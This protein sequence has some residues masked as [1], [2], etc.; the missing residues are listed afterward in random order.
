MKPTDE[1]FDKD[2]IKST[3]FGKFYEDI[4]R[5]WFKNQKCFEVLRGKPKVNWLDRTPSEK[6]QRAFPQFDEL[7]AKSQREKAYCIPDG[8]L[9]IG[10]E[11]F[12]WEAKNWPNWSGGLQPLDQLRDELL[13]L[14]YILAPKLLRGRDY[15]ISGIV[16]TWWSKPKGKETETDELIRQMNSLIAPPTI[17]LYYTVDVLDEC[18]TKQY[19]WYCKIIERERSRVNQLFDDLLPADVGRSESGTGKSP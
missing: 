6:C 17:R 12:I 18:R 8:I 16:F 19:P 4:Y 13:K 5:G 7:L 3:L 1:I 10:E 11:H 2:P 15:D 9:K 14:P